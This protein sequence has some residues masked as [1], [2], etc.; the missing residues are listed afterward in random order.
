MK[1]AYKMHYPHIFR[2]SKLLVWEHKVYAPQT[3]SL[4]GWTKRCVC[5]FEVVFKGVSTCFGLRRIENSFKNA[6]AALCWPSKILRL[7]SINFQINV[8][9]IEFSHLWK[10]LGNFTPPKRRFWKTEQ[11]MKCGFS[12]YFSGVWVPNLGHEPLKSAS[13]IRISSFV[14]PSKIFVWGT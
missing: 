2:R 14:Q 10:V 1:S 5:V 7:G 11:K 4:E 13:K 6:Y 8:A 12:R 3:K 9:Q